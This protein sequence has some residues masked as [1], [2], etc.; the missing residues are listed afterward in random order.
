MTI[1]ETF[2]FC[3]KAPSQDNNKHDIHILIILSLTRSDYPLTSFFVQLP[4]K[5]TYPD[6][7]EIIKNPI[8]LSNM[9]VEHSFYISS[10]SY[11]DP[12]SSISAVGQ[13]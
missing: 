13:D 10:F 8:A 11:I 3:L 4:S 12:C 7:Y 2:F 5:R 1:G 9:K 6:Y